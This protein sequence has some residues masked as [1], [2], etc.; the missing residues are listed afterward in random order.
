MNLSISL[1][2]MC[3]LTGIIL[4]GIFSLSCSAQDAGTR[5]QLFTVNEGLPQN[6]LLGLAQ[7]SAGFIWIGTKDGLARY[8]GYRFKIYRHSKDA[9]HTPAA[10]NI[11]NLYT[12]HRG[13]LWI[14]YDTRAIDCYNPSTGIFEHVSAQPAWD[15]IRSQV[16]GYELIVDHHDNLWVIT[17]KGLYRYQTHSK[18]LSSFTNLPGIVPLAMMEDH[19]GKIWLATQQGFSIYNYSN[20]Q[21]QNI[22]Y[23][24]SARQTYSGRNHK[25]G[26]GEMESGKVIVTSLDS[27]ALV[28]DPVNNS[29]QAVT[30]KI[31][32]H[33]TYDAGL[34]NTNMTIASDGDRWFTCNGRIFRIDKKNDE[35]TEITDPTNPL[36]P[37]A[38]ALLIDRSGTLWFGKDAQG[39]CRINLNTSRFTSKKYLHKNFET[40]ILV[41]ELGVNARDLPAEFDNPAFGYMFRNVTDTLNGL[42]WIQNYLMSLTVPKLMAYDF[43]SKKMITENIFFSK[44]GEVGITADKTGNAWLVGINNWS[45]FKLNYN[46]GKVGKQSIDISSLLPD[47]LFKAG[48]VAINPV[49]DKEMIWVMASNASIDFGTW[50]IISID[51]R[52]KQ[53]RCYPLLPDNAEPSSSL[54][55]MVNDPSNQKY[56]WIGTTGNGLIR[57][58]KTTGLSHAF[59]TDD[60][61][62][63]NTIY[64]IV[65][66]EQHNLWLSSNKGITR[67]DPVTYAVRNFDITDG[68]ISNEFNRWHSFKLPDNRIA[69]GGITGYTIFRPSDI[70]DDDFQP[71]VLL[72]NLLINNKS[73]PDSSS[74]TDSSLNALRKLVLPYDQNFLSFEFASDEYISPEKISYR[75]R[76]SNFDNDWVY[77]RNE[78]SANYTK[79]PPGEYTL[80]VNA[81]NT[82]GLWSNK[83]KTL[84]IIIIPPWWQTWWAYTVY[85][86]AAAGLIISF[87][88]Y[89]LRRIRLRQEMILQQKQTEQLKVIDEMKSRFFSNIT[90]EFR[91][92]LSLI[93]S[94]V[95]KLQGEIK[96]EY[97]NKTLSTIQRNAKRLLHLINQL[98]D[99]SKLEAGNM[100]LNFSR[101][102]LDEFIE[103]MTILFSP[104][105]ENQQIELTCRCKF[106][107]EYL[108]EADKLKTI[109]FNTLSNALKFTSAGGKIAV[110]ATEEENKKIRLSI[111]DTGIGIAPEK[112]PYIFDRFFQADDSRV[113]AYEGTGIGLALVKE[114]AELMHGTV[115][116]ESVRHAGTTITLLFPVEKAGN[117]NAPV[118]KKEIEK[119]ISFLSSKQTTL[120]N[121]QQKVTIET[122]LPLLLLVEDNEEL[123]AFLRESFERNFRVLT[124]SNGLSALQLAKEE[125]PDLVISDVMMP[126]M[127]GYTLCHKLKTDA[128]TGHIAVILLSAKIS[129]ESRLSGLQQGADD[130]ISKPFHFDELETRIRNLLHRQEKQ[131]ENY[132]AQ[133][134]HKDQGSP[135]QTNETANPFLKNIYATIEEMID[136]PQLGASKLAEK[137]AMSLR[138]LNRKL[139]TMIGL[140]A[141]DL[142]RQYRLQKGLALLKEGHNVSE[143]AYMV[144]FETP[145][146]FSQCFKEQYGVSPR[147]YSSV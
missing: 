5:Y 16:I 62:P 91:T 36:I 117:S 32:K 26:I 39:L 82:S 121:G 25:L 57:F 17:E 37:D 56:L 132:R 11:T 126:E 30:L 74:A 10:N 119:D 20:N 75:Y 100:Q 35:I 4:S 102:R 50:N 61:L 14:Q 49:V 133:L 70:K 96:D 99:L 34:G 33:I 90:H 125:L 114:L 73:L 55:M 21:V 28:Y 31:K 44:F 129:Y 58:D 19:S 115:E 144:G 95:E 145:A 136:D 84:Q 94:P 143:A 83:I 104:L 3:L 93:I 86:L 101:G 1:L 147:D 118:W 138:T 52:S 137:N 47:S 109:L 40:D 146:Y 123:L 105:A 80:E 60:G 9:L 13:Y 24:L 140:T 116:A 92:P 15:K 89:R 53:I 69:F 18:Q 128:I 135:G 68:L 97:V 87:F 67:F 42:I 7:D 130:Y 48:K 127:D 12:D 29:F 38:S 106:S 98:M 63:N 139:N 120:V 78:R 54:L 64:A 85:I 110:I 41:N 66:D 2:R 81:S 141:G 27:A 113:R 134:I 72:S 124:A 51:L 77:T 131:R 22:S 6:Y 76:L 79:L 103:E 59:T 23:Q 107:Q 46:N 71:R 45:P 108:F 8:D 88:Y 122:V 43:V 142:I 111:S 65:A 112:L